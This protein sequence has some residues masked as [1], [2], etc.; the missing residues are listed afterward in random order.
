MYSGYNTQIQLQA[1]RS[2]MPPS[3]N[4]HAVTHSPPSAPAA[5]FTDYAYLTNL[6]RQQLLALQHQH[7]AVTYAVDGDDAS[8]VGSSQS[9]RE[10]SGSVSA[11]SGFGTPS[12]GTPLSGGYELSNAMPEFTLARRIG[13]AGPHINTAVHTSWN[14]RGDE[15]MNGMVMK[16]TINSPM[17]VVPNGSGYGMVL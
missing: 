17:H 6:K 4:T 9:G 14:G 13:A 5:G 10:R 7:G 16:Q 11:G 3:S 2:M 15:G 12:R 8:S 1:Q